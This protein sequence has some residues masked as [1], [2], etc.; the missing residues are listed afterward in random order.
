[1]ELSKK[2]SEDKFDDSSL[3]TLLSGSDCGLLDK[4]IGGYLYMN[5]P[6]ALDG[7]IARKLYGSNMIHNVSRLEAYASCGY[8]F[9]L[10]YGLKLRKPEEYIVKSNNIG[11]ILHYVMENFFS[12]LKNIGV[13]YNRQ[14]MEEHN[15]S[16]EYI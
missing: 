1:M 13:D 7:V 3:Y 6:G 9:F 15:I 14:S 4:V 8:Q 12:E 2:L 16:D 10:Q 5:Q 11:T